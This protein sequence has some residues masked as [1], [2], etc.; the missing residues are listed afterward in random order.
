MKAILGIK[1]GMTRVFDG[2]KSTPVTVIDVTGNKI[3]K[4]SNGEI[5]IGLGQKK[6]AVKALVGQYKE[7][8]FVP[9]YKK[10]FRGEIG[11]DTKVGNE[12]KAEI[13]AKGDV[14]T[15]SGVSKGKG[16]AGVVKRWGFSGG[17][18]THGQSDRLRAPGSIGAGS[19]PG[20]VFKGMRMAGRMGSENITIKNKKIVD[21]KENY[22]L[23]NGPVPGSN[24]DLITII[25][26]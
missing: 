12:I 7:L 21:I 2:E 16:F 24:G 11:E 23:I 4:V 17:P 26:E 14:V 13:F 25:S 18:R 1:K 5:E 3:S 15:V 9:A 19:T 6:K 20:R 8:G 22:I 10:V